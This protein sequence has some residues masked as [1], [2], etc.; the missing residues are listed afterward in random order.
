MSTSA[1]VAF[2]VDR[3]LLDRVER[4][5][6]KTGESRSAVIARA[7]VLIT[8]AATRDEQIGRYVAAYRDQPESADDEQVARRTARRSLTHLSREE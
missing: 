3:R 2:S 7:L 1:K 5:R 8:K 6:A 4:L